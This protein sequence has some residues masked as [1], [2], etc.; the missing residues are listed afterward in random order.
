MS[1]CRR[2][3]SSASLDDLELTERAGRLLGRQ[4]GALGFSMDFAPVLDVNTNPEN[5]VIG[6]R[7]FGNEAPGHRS[8]PSPLRAGSRPAGGVLA[9]GKHF[10]GHG[11]TDLDSHLALPAWPTIV[12][13]SS[14][15]NWPPSAPRGPRGRTDDRP[16][17]VRVPWPPGIPATFAPQVVTELLR[18]Q[19]GYDGLVISDDLEMKAIADHYGPEHAACL[20]IEAGCDT[21]L[22]CSRLDW[23]ARAQDALAEKA[24]NDPAF[25]ARLESAVERALATRRAASREPITDPARAGGGPRDPERPASSRGKSPT[26]C[27]R[28]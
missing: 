10:P 15:S 6:D 21:L 8:R 23:L 18:G 22:V 2:C 26:V 28:A 4:L 7:A 27:Q 12:S 3:F 13:V 11:D 24:A 19:L 9:C 14:R 17:R 5:P 20:A 16:C 1:S 25:Q